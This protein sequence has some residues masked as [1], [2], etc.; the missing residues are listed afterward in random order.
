MFGSLL[1]AV[2]GAVIE[3]PV[4]IVRDV[5]TLGGLTDDAPQPHTID[6]LEKV[7]KNIEDSTK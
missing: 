7:L 2:V 6:A 5:V 1:K 3:T 4:A